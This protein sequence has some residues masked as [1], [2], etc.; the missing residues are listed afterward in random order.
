MNANHRKRNGIQCCL[1]TSI[2]MIVTLLIFLMVYIIDLTS[3]NSKIDYYRSVYDINTL[4]CS[5]LCSG[6]PY[7]SIDGKNCCEYQSGCSSKH[8]CLNQLAIKLN[9]SRDNDTRAI[10]ILGVLLLLFLVILCIVSKK[11]RRI[12]AQ[13]LREYQQLRIENVQEPIFHAARNSNRN[14]GRINQS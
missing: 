9:Y 14:V 5:E 4:S 6:L 11:Y 1:C 8:E 12:R 7:Q 10:V 3:K 13:L 2:F